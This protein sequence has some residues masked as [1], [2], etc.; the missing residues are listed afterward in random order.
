MCKGKQVFD[1][2][3]IILFIYNQNSIGNGSKSSLL[4]TLVSAGSVRGRW[5]WASPVRT[6][7]DRLWRSRVLQ[8][9]DSG[10]ELSRKEKANSKNFLFTIA[11]HLD[12]FDIG[13]NLLYFPPVTLVVH[14]TGTLAWEN[15]GPRYLTLQVKNL[16]NFFRNDSFLQRIPYVP[17][18]PVAIRF[19]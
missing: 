12:S 2:S 8:N 3:L 10:K 14:K 1:Y 9:V 18:P 17:T 11:L 19:Y 13:N 16:I 6:R 15:K 5:D 7:S 4:S